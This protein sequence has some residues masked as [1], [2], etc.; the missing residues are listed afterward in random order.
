MISTLPVLQLGATTMVRRVSADQVDC[1]LVKCR[2]FS[3][4]CDEVVDSSS[5]VQLMLFF[6]MVFDDFA[7]KDVALL[8]TT[9][10][11]DI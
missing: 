4:L 1:V 5:M 2:W 6:R 9:R 3:I 10:G 7:M 11:V 8:P